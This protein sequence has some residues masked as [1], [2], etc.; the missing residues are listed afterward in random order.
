MNDEELFLENNSEITKILP[1]DPKFPTG[2]FKVHTKKPKPIFHLGNSIP[3]QGGVSVIGTRNCSQN[4]SA[5]AESVG[6][7]LAEDTI[8]VNSGLAR[9]IDF[10]AHKGCVENDGIS[11]AVLAWFH[12]LYPPE[13]KLLLEKILIKGCAIS[14]TLL[15][16]KNFAQN[17]F[18]ERDKIMAVISDAIIVIESKS[19]GG[20]KF[21]AEYAKKKNIPVVKCKTMTENSD[22]LE[23]HDFFI[24]SGA[25]EANTP[26][27]VIDI[28]SE[29]KSKK[30]NLEKYF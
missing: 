6:K 8:V 21:T 29:L 1:T 25:L 23:G 11:V 12:K 28:L 16:P 30:N 27:S 9:G 22:L 5:F 18:I 19:K 17:Q 24:N 26:E 20:A 10:F 4:G 13:N 14:E 15:M 7:L 2:I 3:L